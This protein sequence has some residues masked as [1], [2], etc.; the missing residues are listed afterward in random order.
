MLALYKDVAVLAAQR[1]ARAWPVAFSLLF[2]GAV[3]IVAGILVRP[4]G[5]VGGFVLGLVAAACA[6]GYLYF[7]SQ[8]VKGLKPRLAE[9]GSSFGALFWDV[10]SV[11]F[12]LFIIGFLV[13]AV[14]RSAG[15]NGD[16]IDA[17]VGL[18]MAFFLNPLPEMI[19]LERARSFEL[20][21]QS[22]RFM[23]AHPLV[24]FLPS[25]LF[26]LALLAPAGQLAVGHP[27]EILL[28]LANFFSPGGVASAFGRLPLWSWPIVLL[29][30]H[31]MMVFRGVLFDSLRSGSARRREWQ[32]RYR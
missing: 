23:L 22:A 6:S 7:L 20:L 17:M 2:F 5:M 29:G 11:M 14:V 21:L 15:S 30:L 4:L 1:A 16:A 24:W 26:A 19:Y 13:T 27:G 31:F 9:L 32:A 10:V 18:A 12:A 28:V 3:M 25:L 8:A